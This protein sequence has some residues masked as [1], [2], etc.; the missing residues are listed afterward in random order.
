MLDE[1]PDTGYVDE[2]GGLAVAHAKPRENADD[3][4]IALRAEHRVRSKERVAVERG[5]GGEI[6]RAHCFGDRAGHV[7]P[8]VLEQR[9]EVVAG[10]TDDRV[11]KIEQAASGG[12]SPVGPIEGRYTVYAETIRI[13]ITSKPMLV[14]CAAIEERIRGYFK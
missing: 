7:A 5:E 1:A 8:S 13:T 9:D 14:P 4:A 10:G 6:P 12:A 11:L 3:L 2:I